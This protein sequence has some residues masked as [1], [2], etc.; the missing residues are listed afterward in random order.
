MSFLFTNIIFANA[1]GEIRAGNID[2]ANKNATTG[3]IISEFLGV[4]LLVIAM[5][6]AINAITGD[7]FLK[8]AVFVTSMA[9]LFGYS[10]SSF[11]IIKRYISAIYP[12]LVYVMVFTAIWMVCFLTQAG[13]S[14]AY[15]CSSIALFVYLILTV[16][17]LLGYEK[18]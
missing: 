17:F 6:L 14:I 3:N 18:S 9:A 1:S 7:A 8:F 13:D 11:S 15:L 10:V 5:P 2:G 4:Y 12:R 16:I